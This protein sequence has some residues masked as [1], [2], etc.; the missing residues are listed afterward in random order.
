[1]LVGNISRMEWNMLETWNWYGS[2]H[3]RC[4]KIMLNS[5]HG[6]HV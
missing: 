1:V 4:K 2:S 3:K 6:Y 5:C